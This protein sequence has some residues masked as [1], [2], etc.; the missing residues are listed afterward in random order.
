[1]TDDPSAKAKRD[2][3]EICRQ[4]GLTEREEAAAIDLSNW[5]I[6][7]AQRQGN[8]PRPGV[9]KIFLMHAMIGALEP[10][11]CD[12]AQGFC[13][14]FDDND[15]N[16][17]ERHFASAMVPPLGTYAMQHYAQHGGRKIYLTYAFVR[18]IAELG[19][20]IHQVD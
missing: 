3:D 13:E 7:Y 14:Q 10:P 2:A 20:F 12:A 1:M 9:R 17:K 6:A 11:I 4:L 16:N 18:A 5:L 19:A 8:I 15:L